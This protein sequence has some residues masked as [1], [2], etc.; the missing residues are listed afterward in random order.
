MNFCSSG[1]WFDSAVA[2]RARGSTTRAGLALLRRDR[3]IEGSAD[4][5]Y[6][7]REV[8]GSSNSFTYQRL[9]GEFDLINFESATPRTVSGGMSAR[10]SSPRS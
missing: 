6:R 3:V 8:F 7:P 10:R 5:G 1:V 2:I 4:D 9:F